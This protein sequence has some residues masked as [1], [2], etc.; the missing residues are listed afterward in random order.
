MRKILEKHKDKG[1]EPIDETRKLYSYFL[2]DSHP[3]YL[4]ILQRILRQ[5]SQYALGAI[6]Q[7]LYTICLLAKLYLSCGTGSVL[8]RGIT[9]L[10]ISINTTKN[11]KMIFAKWLNEGCLKAV[12]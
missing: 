8:L 10:S 11:S 7:P 9:A 6:S 1:G 2:K 4:Y 3:N 5:G 12:E